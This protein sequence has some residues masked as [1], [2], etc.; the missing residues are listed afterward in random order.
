M[1]RPITQEMKARWYGVLEGDSATNNRMVIAQLIDALVAEGEPEATRFL[2]CKA[3]GRPVIDDRI[4]AGY[5][6]LCTPAVDPQPEPDEFKAWD[7][8]WDR[9]SYGLIQ[10]EE[11]AGP[12]ARFTHNGGGVS[13]NMVHLSIP[14][15][16]QLA[17]EIGTDDDGEPIYA[18]AWEVGSVDE[19]Q[20]YF[21]PDR[22][23]PETWF[24][25]RVEVNALNIPI[26]TADQVKRHWPNGYPG[27]D[28]A[29]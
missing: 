3:C 29:K 9:G 27:E 17:K 1:S 12:Y 16:S 20:V 22:Y 8:A 14:T 6:I 11:L 5:C 15:R 19:V 28:D 21:D 24:C 18:W 25:F 13:L 10:I 26:I 2:K 7:W 23:A 4:G